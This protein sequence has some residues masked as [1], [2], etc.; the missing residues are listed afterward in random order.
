MRMH[1]TITREALLGMLDR[2]PERWRDLVTVTGA[3]S[4]DE[5]RAQVA[6]GPAVYVVGDCDNFDTEKGRC[7]GHPSTAPPIRFATR[8]KPRGNPP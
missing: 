3:E 7:L 2:D 5:A 8:R 1:M 4:F 6:N